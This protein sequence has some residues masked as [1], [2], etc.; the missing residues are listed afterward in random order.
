MMNR[1]TYRR[2]GGFTLAETMMTMLIL[3][4]VGAIL[5]AGVPTAVHAYER[6]VD[7]AN[8]QLL[9]STTVS[10]LEEE[11]STAVEVWMT[12]E[13]TSKKLAGFSHY[14]GGYRIK[15]TNSDGTAAEGA[16]QKQEKGVCLEYSQRDGRTIEKGAEGKPDDYIWTP[17]NQMLVTGQTRTNKFYV[18]FG[19][20]SYADGVFTVTELKVMKKNGDTSP[21]ELKEHLKIRTVKTPTEIP[22]SSTP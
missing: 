9:L 16:A 19:D 18:Q 2:H 4:M 11:L 21:M 14:Q 12:G 8:A 6:V 1:K 7:A 20:I 10:R 5:V 3:V 15:I 17:D 22:V 13:G